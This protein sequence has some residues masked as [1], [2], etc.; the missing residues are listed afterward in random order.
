MRQFLLIAYFIS[1]CLVIN[2]SVAFCSDKITFTTISHGNHNGLQFS[3]KGLIIINTR[4]KWIEIYPKIIDNKDYYLKGPDIDF[5]K[6][7]VIVTFCGISGGGYK[8]VIDDV[9]YNKVKNH[10]TIEA[11]TTIPDINC[12]TLSVITYPYNIVK[13]N[14]FNGPMD[15]NMKYLKYRCN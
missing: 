2:D 5:N 6:F 13:I 9:I 10:I 3:D 8:F 7:T 4:S 12:K 15:I 1:L 11:T 14:K